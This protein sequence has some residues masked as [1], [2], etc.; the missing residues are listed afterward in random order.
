V[1]SYIV[2]WEGESMDCTIRP[3]TRD[4]VPA[5]QEVMGFGFGFDPKPEATENLRRIAELDRTRCAFDGSSMVGTSGAFS[6]DLTVPGGSL[7]TAGTT[8][9]SVR[10]THRRQGLLRAMMRAHIEDVRERNEPLAALWA[11]ESGI[12][13]RFGYGPASYMCA[14]EIERAHSLFAQP[15]SG[16]GQF[17]LLTAEEAPKLFPRVYDRVYR[18]RPGHFARSTVWWEA[19]AFDP[20]WERRGATQFRYALYEEAGE[21][22]GYIQYRIRQ[23]WEDSGLPNSTLLIMELQGID[24]NARAALWRYALDVDLVRSIEAWNRPVDESLPWLLADPRRLH[25]S[26]R[27]A[28]WVRVVDVPRALEGRAYA[29]DGHLVLGVRDEFCPWN[30]GTYELAAAADGVE[31][32]R[33]RAEPEIRLT[34]AELGAVYLG[35]NRFSTLARA[36]RIEGPPDALR[37]ADALFT[38]DPPPWCP[39]VF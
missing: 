26:Q 25:W 13:G 35:G 18:S 36:G 1:Y 12:Y 22:R 33:S 23:A 17:R 31:C 8:L 5:M 20:E 34:A 10:S 7:P 16:A 30:D 14:L 24:G 19:R 15:L 21:A 29:S 38:W 4:E 27:D 39:E 37:R 9:V 11:A 28:L 6:L 32:R 2:F 3:A